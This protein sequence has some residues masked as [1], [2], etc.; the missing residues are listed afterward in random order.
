M[1]VIIFPLLVILAA[2]YSS[3]KTFTRCKL[4]HVLLNAK[5]SQQ[6]LNDWVCLAESSSQLNTSALGVITN[7]FQSIGLFQVAI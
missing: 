4:A 2:S 6:Q 5:F 7:G 1:L 3:A